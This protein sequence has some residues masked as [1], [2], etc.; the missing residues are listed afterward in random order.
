MR[1]RRWWCYLRGLGLTTVADGVLLGLLLWVV[2]LTLPL[3]AL[4]QRWWSVG[5]AV[6]IYAEEEVCWKGKQVG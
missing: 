6:Y 1:G 4:L 3:L 2:P 5:A